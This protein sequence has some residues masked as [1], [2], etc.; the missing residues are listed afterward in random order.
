MD[1]IN[2]I[3]LSEIFIY[4]VA[5]PGN[6]HEAVTPCADGY[7]V[8]INQNLTYEQKVKAFAHALL[9][10]QNRDF[11]KSDDVQTIEAQAHS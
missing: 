3:D 1:S 4:Q 9:H 11:E 7:T 5:L 10:I 2:N 8:Y 6:V